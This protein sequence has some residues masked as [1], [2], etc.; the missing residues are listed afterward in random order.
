[1]KLEEVEA[2][3]I[4]REDSWKCFFLYKSPIKSFLKCVYI[5]MFC[6]HVGQCSCGAPKEQN[7]S[8]RQL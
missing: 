3:Q 2:A 5:Y 1:M 7:W 6:L 4:T 8:Y